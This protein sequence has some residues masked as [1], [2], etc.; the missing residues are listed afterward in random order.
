MVH[1]VLF[2]ITFT[3]TFTNAYSTDNA[4]ALKSIR[5]AYRM[6]NSRRIPEDF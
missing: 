3:K 6:F 5:I 4:T 1:P 2:N